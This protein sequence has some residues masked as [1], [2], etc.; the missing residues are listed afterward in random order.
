M[1]TLA[2]GPGWKSARRVTH[3][4]LT[5]SCTHSRP[6]CCRSVYESGADCNLVDWANTGATYRTYYR[7]LEPISIETGLGPIEVTSS[8]EQDVVTA[9]HVCAYSDVPTK[10][11]LA[12]QVGGRLGGRRD[13]G[14]GCGLCTGQAMARIPCPP[15]TP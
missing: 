10:C 15:R 14:A 11:N 8:E 5:T 4:T 6:P 3:L 13:C 1:S 7:R 12:A 9:T 2:C